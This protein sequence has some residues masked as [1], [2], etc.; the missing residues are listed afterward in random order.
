MFYV[1]SEK[2]IT[3]SI[4]SRSA[5]VYLKYLWR[6]HYCIIPNCLSH[7]KYAIRKSRSFD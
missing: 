3:L 7:S 4:V 1:I 6:L 5:L 2:K